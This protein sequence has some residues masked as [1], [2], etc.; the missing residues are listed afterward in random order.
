VSAWPPPSVPPPAPPAGWYA[1]PERVGEARWWDGQR[2]TDDRTGGHGDSA[3]TLPLAAAL[4]GLAVL[5]AVGGGAR[6]LAVTPAADRLPA[7]LAVVVF[8]GVL[9]GSMTG[10]CAFAARRWG[11]GGFRRVHGV[12]LR[13]GDL[14]W[15]VLAWFAAVMLGGFVQ[16][17]LER[18]DVP[19]RSNVEALDGLGEDRWLALVFALVAVVA[20]PFVEEV[21]F[22][23]MLQ[24]S[25][26]SRFRPAVAVGL[27]AVL[28]GVYH[29]DPSFGWGNVGLVAVLAT[30]GAVFGVA[31]HR[32]GRLGA[33]IV[34]HAVVNALALAATLAS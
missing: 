12:R 22:R 16:S 1:D 33:A 26:A 29:V 31:T 6:L 4:G 8:Y 23:G 32:T 3:P 10:W 7:V 15:G 19:F 18:V 2:W 13:P 17:T 14:G 27:Q 21:F 30:A 25:F 20:A 34:A 5:T 28:F 24:R 9:F 11:A